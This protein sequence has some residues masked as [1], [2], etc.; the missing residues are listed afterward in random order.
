MSEAAPTTTEAAE[1]KSGN[2]K[3][4]LFSY[5]KVVFLYPTFA[6]GM[7]AGI[8][9]LVTA[10]DSNLHGVMATIFLATLA[11]NL[12]IFSFDF[13][14]TT[15][16]TLFFLIAAIVLGFLLLI[17]FQ[18]D[19]LPML[20]HVVKQYSPHANATFYFTICAML[21]FI[22]LLVALFIRFDYWEVRNNE[23]LH[24]TGFL[25]D[26]K[27]YSA[28]HIKVEKEINDVFEYMLLGSGRLIL[29]TPDE[30]RSI[31]LDTVPFIDRKEASLTRLL[32]SLQV[33]VKPTNE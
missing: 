8:M 22:F 14:R 25:S 12:V 27:R 1:A 15:S 10:A 29:T 5:P 16:L 2:E 7:V 13:P 31:I 21:A 23:L 33:R 11:V 20:T 28:P 9:E 32:G 17:Q 30:T 6:V 24:H 26:L 3:V 4:F 18:P 19:L